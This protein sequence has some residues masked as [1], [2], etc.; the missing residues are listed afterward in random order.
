MALQTGLVVKCEARNDPAAHLRTLVN[1]TRG[2]GRPDPGKV[3]D[4]FKLPSCSRTGVMVVKYYRDL[5]PMPRPLLRDRRSKTRI[6][7][8]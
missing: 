8:H 1:G 6:D 3:V 2:G 4:F 5:R 7:R